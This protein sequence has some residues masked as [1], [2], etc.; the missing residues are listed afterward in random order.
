MKYLFLLLI[1]C[2]SNRL[3]ALPPLNEMKA[4]GVFLS[5]KD[6]KIQNDTQSIAND[7]NKLAGCTIFSDIGDYPVRIVASND[8]LKQTQQLG[9]TSAWR[10][11]DNRGAEIYMYT[12]DQYPK[13]GDWNITFLHELGHSLGLQHTEYHG[14]MYKKYGKTYSPDYQTGLNEL[15]LLLNETGFMP[16]CVD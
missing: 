4:N 13:D 14:I 11:P 15:L 1:G 16:N 12:H 6:E 3:E 7:L 5:S 2:G 10:A 9:A 8:D